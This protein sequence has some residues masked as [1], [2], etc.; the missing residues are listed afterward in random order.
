MEY[1]RLVLTP[2]SRFGYY[3]RALPSILYANAWSGGKVVSSAIASKWSLI[4]G[5]GATLSK[6]IVGCV[7]DLCGHLACKA[8]EARRLLQTPTSLGG[9]GIFCFG[10]RP[11]LT[12]KDGAIALKTPKITQV[13]G[14][15]LQAGTFEMLTKD[16][17]RMAISNGASWYQDDWMGD[18][19]AKSVAAGVIMKQKPIEE[20]E[21][22][23][24]IEP[25]DYDSMHHVGWS[26]E[27]PPTP[28]IDNFFLEEAVRKAMGEKDLRRVMSFFECKDHESIEFRYHKWARNVWFDWI[29]G[30][31]TVPVGR[32]WGDASDINPW[33]RKNIRRSG[34]Y[35]VTPTLG[36]S[37]AAVRARMVRVECRSAVIFKDLRLRFRG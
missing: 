16:D 28:V 11:L 14:R 21:V 3:W 12:H 26:D 17:Q 22:L 29:L 20:R 4:H 31:L 5:R 13:G 37:R 34:G 32:C 27:P 1:L 8:D 19:C 15:E 30:R 23:A 33:I 18:V 25:V 35:G 2:T 6:T 36:R 10:E 9:L 24:P 7:R